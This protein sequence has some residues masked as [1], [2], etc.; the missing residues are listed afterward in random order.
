MWA[1]EVTSFW[2]SIWETL[3]KVYVI[4]FKLVGSW[5]KLFTN[6][7]LMRQVGQNP[8]DPNGSLQN[9]NWNWRNSNKIWNSKAWN[10]MK[11]SIKLQIWF[12]EIYFHL[13]LWFSIR[14]YFYYG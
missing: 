10:L 9:G 1:V 4:W 12:K 13:W 3:S 11:F 7:H 5:T 6:E 14:V 2:W 8:H